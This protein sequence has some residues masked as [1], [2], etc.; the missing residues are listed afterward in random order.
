MKFLEKII[1]QIIWKKGN[2]I[3]WIDK[4]IEEEI[5]LSFN[6]LNYSS[7]TWLIINFLFFFIF[8]FL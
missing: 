3:T 4:E 7:E 2:I 8:Y 5:A 1:I 6:N